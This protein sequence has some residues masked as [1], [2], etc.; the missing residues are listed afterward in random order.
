MNPERPLSGFA[1][2]NGTRL[3]YEA[4]GSGIPLL[5]LHG[6]TFDR[7]MWRPQLDAL[8]KHHL[9]VSYDARGFGRS[10]LPGA[11]QYRHCDDA[12][13]LCEYLEL[14][15]VVAVGH[16]IGAH[17]LLELTL[18]RPERVRGFVAIC[19]A[20]LHGVPF[21]P[22]LLATFGELRAVAGER[23]VEA[24]KRIWA[25]S[26]WF[27]TSRENPGVVAAMDEILADYSGWHWTHD[28]PAVGLQPAAATRLAELRV[29]SLI[30][31]GERDVP[32]SDDVARV[33]LEGTSGATEL[34][35]A[36]AGHMAN[37]DAPSAVNRAILDFAAE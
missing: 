8:A 1:D 24:A 9:V 32:Y 4:Q 30:I 17:Q 20:G 31:T 33:L 22:D 25:R 3:Y 28:N 27:R 26:P 19:M 11:D 29:K 7:R 23:G 21:T 10:A 37:M 14:E 13:A 2:V 18:S 5:L 16:S 12:A 34:R 6:F 35:V 15:P 36:G